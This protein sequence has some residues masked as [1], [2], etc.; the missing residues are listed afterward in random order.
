M[1]LIYM[2]SCLFPPAQGRVKNI[3]EV[4]QQNKSMKKQVFKLIA[5]VVL[6]LALV[7]SSRAQ[8]ANGAA[9]SIPAYYDHVL[10][11]IHFVEFS[12]AAEK[13][14]LQHNNSLNLIYQSDPGLPGGQPFIS[15]IDAI[16][17]DGF[18]PIWQEVQ[19]TFK[20]GHTPRQLFSDDEI[21]AAFTAGEIMLTF[22]GEVYWCPVV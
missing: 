8:V 18:N 7:A 15:V 1:H 16:P 9:S 21:A 4:S 19:I 22:T 3:R 17:G 20:A 6:M 14:L 5:G 12:P 11:T 2:G 13:A 10:F